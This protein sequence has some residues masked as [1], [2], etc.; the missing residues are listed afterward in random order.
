LTATGSSQ[1]TAFQLVASTNHNF[2][3]VGSGTGCV[4]PSVAPPNTVGIWNGGT[5]T[6]NVYPPVGGKLNSGNVNA[7]IGLAVKSGVTY[8]CV[9]TLT[10]ACLSPAGGGSSGS[11]TVTSVGTGS[12]LAGG[13]ITGS[14][15]I[16]LASLAATSLLGNP[17]GSSAAPQSI[18][19]GANLSI[20]SGNLTAAG[21]GSETVSSIATGTGLTGGP[22]TGSGTIAL[23]NIPTATLLGNPTGGSAAPQSIG[24]GANLSIVSGNLTAA[25]GGSGTVT[26]VASGTGLTGGPITGSGTIALANIPTATLLGNPTGGSAAP[27]A[28]GLGANLSF[29]SGNLVAAG[30]GGSGTV[31]S[32][33][34]GP[35]L[36]GGTISGSGMIALATPIAAAA[37]P[38]TGLR[39]TQHVSP[40]T[41]DAD[42]STITFDLSV[43]DWHTVTLGGNRTLALA[44]PTVG[45]Q[46]AIILHNCPA[47]GFGI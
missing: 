33:T 12:G 35:G 41:A 15:T 45:Q 40:I 5:N 17:T 19:L 39:I 25:G 23:A 14:G 2:S 3:S 13:P 38:A 47:N 10:W 44:N 4:L 32:V 26:S 11:G 29:V 42:G 28:I 36:T 16:S 7:P 30:G 22:I 9:D 27:Q 31:T 24:L 46:F 1:A 18:G 6:L 20:V 8:T 43:S 21:G 37:L 34:A